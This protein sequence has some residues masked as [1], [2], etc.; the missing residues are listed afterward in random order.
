MT[1]V[2]PADNNSLVFITCLLTEISSNRTVNCDA[3]G[4]EI[5]APPLRRQHFLLRLLTVKRRIRH[6][7]Y[8]LL[9]LRRYAGKVVELLIRN[10]AE[11]RR[12]DHKRLGVKGRILHG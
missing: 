12:S 11:M 1:A 2:T 8:V 3:R 5:G 10:P 7:L 4:G 9:H 6:L